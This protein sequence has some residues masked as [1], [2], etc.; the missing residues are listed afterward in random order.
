VMTEG[1]VKICFLHRQLN[2]LVFCF[3]EKS[4][5]EVYE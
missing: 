5:L 4:S 1:V 2:L 3:F